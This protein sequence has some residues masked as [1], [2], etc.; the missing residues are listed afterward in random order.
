MDMVLTTRMM[1]ADEAERSGLVSRIVPD[2][3]LI[4]D[5]IAIATQIAGY[6]LPVVMEA[7]EAVSRA[8]ESSLAESV[9]FERRFFHALFAIQDQ[10]EGM[11]AFLEK[12]KPVFRNRWH[13]SSNVVAPAA[14]RLC[15]NRWV[16][17]HTRNAT[18]NLFSAG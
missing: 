2:A 10:K 6:S 12:R 17:I 1:N 8:F 18:V 7:K 16:D 13:R 15:M 14:S 11:R 9:Q 5:S 4:E 3:R